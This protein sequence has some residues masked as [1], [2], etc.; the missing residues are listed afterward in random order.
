MLLLPFSVIAQEQVEAT[1]V[2]IT[3]TKMK[4]CEIA[5]DHSHRGSAQSANAIVAAEF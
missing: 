4:A 2:G 3:D 1:G 5:L